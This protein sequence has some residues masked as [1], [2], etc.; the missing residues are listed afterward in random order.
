M[1][2]AIVTDSTADIPQE[3]AEKHKIHVVPAI[4]IIDGQSIEDGKGLTRREFY[5]RMPTMQTTP[6]TSTPS[7]GKFH[8]VYQKLFQQ[9]YQ[10]IISIHVSSL[11][12]G[13]YNTA[14]SAAQAFSN[15]VKVIDSG[16]LSLG[17]GFQV[18][19]AAKGAARGLSLDKVVQQVENIRQRVRIFAMLDTL[20]Y[21]RRS[22]R[23]SWARARIGAILQIKPFLEIK[24]GKVLSLGQVR[25]RSK[26][27]PQLI[28]MV[29]NLGPLEQLAVL[30]T[31]AESE[32]RKM[33]ENLNISLPDPVLIVN[34]TTIIGT[35]VGP[36]GLGFA[37][38]IK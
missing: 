24:N 5:E 34:V 11:L 32:A 29:R 1:S 33:L 20:E 26:G 9:G 6:T 8:D 31:N 28:E 21:V 30:H 13:I 12:S 27:I 22:G 23:V 25:T 17:L 2:I 15:K 16:Q 4:L 37:A 38:V 18:L 14:T 35:H 3:L 7:A 10:E 36:N 19:A